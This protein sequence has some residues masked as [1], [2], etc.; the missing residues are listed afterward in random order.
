M[1]VDTATSTTF[2]AATLRRVKCIGLLSSRNN[3]KVSSATSSFSSMNRFSVFGV[4]KK[5]Y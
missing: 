5:Q 3:E 1:R 2:D 4:E